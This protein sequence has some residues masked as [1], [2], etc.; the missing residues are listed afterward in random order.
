MADIYNREGDKIASVPLSDNQIAA[1]DTGT[2]ITVAW[3]TP[4]ALRPLFA[5]E[6]GHFTLRKDGEHIVTDTPEP[7]KKCATMQE[8]LKAAREQS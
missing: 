7:V 1:L 4:F 5:V 3:H 2:E 8:A 6:S